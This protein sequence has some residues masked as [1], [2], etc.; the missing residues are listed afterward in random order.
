MWLNWGTLEKSHLD[1]A[2]GEFTM[3]VS[4]AWAIACIS[5]IASVLIVQIRRNFWRDRH[6]KLEQRLRQRYERTL[7]AADK[8]SAQKEAYWQAQIQSVTAQR[9]DLATQNAALQHHLDELHQ[10]QAQL[11]IQLADV[12]QRDEL[13]AQRSHLQAEINDLEQQRDHLETQLVHQATQLNTHADLEALIQQKEQLDRD[14]Q[15]LLEIQQAMTLNIRLLLTGYDQAV[16]QHQSLDGKIIQL[17][18][19]LQDLRQQRRLDSDSNQELESTAAELRREIEQLEQRKVSLKQERQDLAQHYME[20]EQAIAQYERFAAANQQL[21]EQIDEL[22]VQLEQH[23]RELLELEGDRQHYQTF[24]NCQQRI[25]IV[26]LCHSQSAEIFHA[27]LDTNF[28]TVIEAL[29]FAEYLFSDILEIW[30]SARA[31]AYQINFPRPHDVYRNLQALAWIGQ[32]FFQNNGELGQGLYEALGELQCDY[33]SRESDATQNN[34][35]LLNQRN[36]Y[37]NTDNQTEQKIMLQHLK[38]GTGRGAD[39]N[40]R[41]YFDLNREKQRVEIGYCGRH[42][43]T[44]SSS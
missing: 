43:D 33:S 28:N 24:R 30:D 5:V 11:E 1:A 4:V 27:E 44:V 25:K 7:A 22:T 16:V 18:D 32:R 19:H 35:R 39:Q 14:C 17:Q 8:L 40:L 29:E 37:H 9:E 41:I 13:T 15:Q 31:S 6:R 10:Q 23:R 21:Q 26:A 2:L 12:Q 34:A 38:V 3:L 36:F 20:H 42:L